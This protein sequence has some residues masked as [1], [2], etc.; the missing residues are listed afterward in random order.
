[1]N[2]GDYLIIVIHI[3]GSICLLGYVAIGVYHYCIEHPNV[4]EYDGKLQDL[5]NE[6]GEV[7]SDIKDYKTIKLRKALVSYLDSLGENT[8]CL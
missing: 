8:T 3:F 6:A 4:I 5:L 7:S 2:D 1:M